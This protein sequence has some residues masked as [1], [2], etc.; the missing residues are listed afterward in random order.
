MKFIYENI[1]NKLKSFRSKSVNMEKLITVDYLEVISLY[2][3]KII[4]IILSQKGTKI[5][6]DKGDENQE[7]SI[8]IKEYGNIFKNPN[9]FYKAIK[10]LT[11]KN[12]ITKVAGKQSLYYVNPHIMSNMTYQQEVDAGLKKVFNDK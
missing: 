5:G 6:V 1:S 8:S 12:F 3:C 10:N 11:E 4:L 9:L 2:E 7:C